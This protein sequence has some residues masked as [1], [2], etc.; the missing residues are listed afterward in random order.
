MSN[1]IRSI[2]EIQWESPHHDSIEL[3]VTF[4]PVSGTSQNEERI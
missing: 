2:V 3:K 1:K 4:V